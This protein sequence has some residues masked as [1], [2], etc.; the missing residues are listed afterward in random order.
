M[1]VGSLVVGRTLEGE[2]AVADS[3]VI[4]IGS[5]YRPEDGRSL[6]VNGGVAGDLRRVVLVIRRDAAHLCQR[7]RLIHVGDADGDILLDGVLPG[8]G[9]DGHRIDV[10]A[11]GVGGSLVVRDVGEVQDTAAQGEVAPVGAGQRPRG[12]YTLRVGDGVGGECASDVLRI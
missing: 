12:G 7:G 2:R 10:V 3:E 9:L 8:G 5:G 1:A 11:T 6:R 4:G